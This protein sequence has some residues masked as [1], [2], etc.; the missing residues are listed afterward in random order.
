MSM[1]VAADFDAAKPTQREKA[2]KRRLSAAWALGIGLLAGVADVGT[3]LS[4]E[5][6]MFT[7]KNCAYCILWERQLGS[8]YPRSAEAEIAPL[9]RIDLDDA[10]IAKPALQPAVTITPTF[11]LM[12]GGREVGR[13]LGYSDDLT[14]W[15]VLATHLKKLPNKAASAPNSHEKPLQ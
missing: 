13:F 11:V 8:I 4:A 6:L 5:L 9:R 12:D 14:F 15:S 3:A 1:P 7:R 10:T 2:G